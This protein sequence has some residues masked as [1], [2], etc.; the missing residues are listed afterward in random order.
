MSTERIPIKKG[1]TF[2][3]DCEAMSGTNPVNLTGWTI[4]SGLKFQD[5]YIGSFTVT[6]TNAA[7]GLYTLSGLNTS[8]W[9]V[10]ILRADIKYTNPQGVVAY[11]KTFEIRCEVG[12][13]P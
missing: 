1:G 3:L 5:K 8:S 9:P 11:T 6:V 12:I 13:T 4:Q 10:G 2:R 7:N